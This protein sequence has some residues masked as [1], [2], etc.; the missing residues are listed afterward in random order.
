MTGQV[1]DHEERREEEEDSS[2]DQASRRGHNLRGEN[3]KN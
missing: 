2:V 1:I 3:D